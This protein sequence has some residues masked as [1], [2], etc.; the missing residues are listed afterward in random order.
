MRMA[1]VKNGRKWSYTDL[2]AQTDV[3]HGYIRS[4]EVRPQQVAAAL[5]TECHCGGHEQHA[6]VTGA[7]EHLART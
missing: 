5:A 6:A 3:I 7:N 4:E 1:R 2:R